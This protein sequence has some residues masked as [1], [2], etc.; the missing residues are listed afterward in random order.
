MSMHTS[1]VTYYTSNPSLNTMIMAGKLHLLTPSSH[2][3][4]FNVSHA[5]A[6]NLLPL[7]Y[8]TA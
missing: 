6:N 8:H 3:A 2:V 7:L 4:L 5:H 1:H